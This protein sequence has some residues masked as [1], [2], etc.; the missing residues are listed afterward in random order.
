MKKK[1]QTHNQTKQNIFPAMQYFIGIMNRYIMLGWVF[2]KNTSREM[3]NVH[4]TEG[5][6]V[7]SS[8]KYPGSGKNERN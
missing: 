5:K 3:K 2:A 6:K 1:K 8:G 7:K 4:G